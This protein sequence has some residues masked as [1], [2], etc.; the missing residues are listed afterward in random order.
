[1]SNQP[2]EV[3]TT[4]LT[5]ELN[6]LK[7]PA[8]AELLTAVELEPH[9]KKD[10]MI[11]RMKYAISAGL[12]TSLFDEGDFDEEIEA[13]SQ[14]KPK[15]EPKPKK[16]KPVKEPKPELV[17]N[18]VKSPYEGRQVFTSAGTGKIISQSDEADTATND[19][20]SFFLVAMAD[21]TQKVVNEA[22]TRFKAVNDQYR[23]KYVK[24][25]SIR[26]ESGSPSVHSGHVVSRALLGFTSAE[27]GQVYTENGLKVLFDTK[28][29]SGR[30][31]GMVRMDLGNILIARYKKDIPF[32]I[33]GEKDMEVAA[34]AGDERGEK[35]RLAAEAA[36]KERDEKIAAERKEK[37]DA[38]AKAKLES[39]DKAKER[40][41]ERL[42][43]RDEKK[44]AAEAKKIAEAKPKKAVKA[45]KAPKDAVS[46]GAKVA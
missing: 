41:A 36:K 6:K 39:A 5:V 3:K 18:W 35:M 43:K 23:E 4:E 10:V 26:T 21:G 42:A 13:A 27:I 14:P 16:E 11:N 22:T 15:A 33:Q 30:N 2:T 24:D 8:L 29:E 1:M 32:T 34:K 40:E 12:Y 37:A 45:P 17:L 20:K 7:K 19:G 28:V 9:S 44:A 31:H 46:R 25:K 38:K